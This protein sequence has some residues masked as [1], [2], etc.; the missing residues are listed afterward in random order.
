VESFLEKVWNAAHQTRLV[1]SLAWPA[2]Q[3][4]AIAVGGVLVSRMSRS[5]DRH[6]AFAAGMVLAVLGAGVVGSGGDWLRYLT[7][8]PSSRVVPELELSGFGALAGLVLGHAL[9]ARGDTRRALDGLAPSVGAMLC[10]SRLGCFFAGCDFG[11]PTT[12]P[13]GLRYPHGTPAFRA[14]LAAGLVTAS[15]PTTLT[16]HPSPL[17]ESLLGLFMLGLALASRARF[18]RTIV[19]Y[20]A[21]RFV[22]DFF[23][24]DLAHGPLGLTMSQYL[25]LATIGCAV[26]HW[27][28]PQTGTLA[29]TRTSPEDTRKRD[30]R[31]LVPR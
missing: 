21:S 1:P 25:A 17:Y 13:W 22:L 3:V 28:E 16:V 10:I 19:V 11:A 23:R 18:A 6:R 4:A 31:P 27:H 14:E 7:A 2:F 5:K 26:M 20:A 24:G 30:E 15:S 9:V 8:G 12:L 29:V